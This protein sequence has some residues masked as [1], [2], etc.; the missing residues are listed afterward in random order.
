[1]ITKVYVDMDGVLA[2]FV[3]R[4]TESQPD[5]DYPSN[6]KKR[7]AY[8]QHWLDFIAANNFATLEPMPD[9]DLGLQFLNKIQA[10]MPVRILGSTAREEFLEPL[11]R[12]KTIWLKHHD[13]HFRRIFVPGKRLKQNYS[14]PGKVLIDDTPSNILQWEEQGGIGILHISWEQTIKEFYDYRTARNN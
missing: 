2:N 9:L 10:E 1:M 12:Q 14:G 11:V 7:T 8:K 3:K 6:N 5:I 4:F 13:I